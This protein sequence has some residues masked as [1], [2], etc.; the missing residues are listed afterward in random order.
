[1]K[2]LLSRR[3]PGTARINLVGIIAFFISLLPCM[4]AA[5]A[6]VV[7]RIVA[8]VNNDVI[9]LYELEKHALPY[10][11]KIKA[12]DYPPSQETALIK[13]LMIKMLNELIDLKLAEQEL[14]K[15]KIK[16]SDQEV[17]RTIKRMVDARGYTQEQLKEGLEAEGMTMEDYRERIK[18]QLERRKL[19]NKEVRSKIVITREDVEKYFEENKSKYTGEKKVRLRNIVLKKPEDEKDR[20]V[21]LNQMNEILSE[22]NN[23]KSFQTM[24]TL[25]SDS[26]FATEGGD[27]GFFKYSDLSPDLKERLKGKKAGDHTEVMD[28]DYGYQIFY[29]D[30]IVE[31]REKRLEEVAPEIEDIL[32]NKIID[33]EYQAWLK[34][35]RSSSHIKVIEG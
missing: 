32:Y 2:H 4:D 24:A 28:T 34:H 27:L 20:E 21:A 33:Q 22:L 23:G 13:K 9:S 5:G 8:I 25:Y 10:V 16:V 3:G 15:L 6:D 1:M 7:D 18:K 31:A 30:E 17:D 14:E 26:A 35:L 12:S 19:V 29:V 11:N